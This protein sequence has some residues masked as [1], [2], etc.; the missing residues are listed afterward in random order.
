MA[1]GERRKTEWNTPTTQAVSRGHELLQLPSI[2]SRSVPVGKNRERYS[3]AAISL[4]RTREKT[5]DRDTRCWVEK[6][7]CLRDTE[8]FCPSSNSGRLNGPVWLLRTREA[9]L[10]G[11]LVGGENHAGFRV[12]C[13]D[14]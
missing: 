2:R 5:S 13:A 7:E 6:M 14:G 9:A 3:S 10:D 1:G 4:S 11:L 8:I 12:F